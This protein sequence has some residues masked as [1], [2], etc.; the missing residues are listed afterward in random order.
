MFGLPS[1]RHLYLMKQRMVL[2]RGIGRPAMTAMTHG[3]FHRLKIKID[4]IVASTSPETHRLWRFRLMFPQI[5]SNSFLGV[6]SSKFLLSYCSSALKKEVPQLCP[7]LSHCGPYNMVASIPWMQFMFFLVKSSYLMVP[8]SYNA[9][10][11]TPLQVVRHTT[12]PTLDGAAF[13]N[14][15][16]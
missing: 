15:A 1:P 5:E 8:R 9:W 14:F 12:N 2:G 7:G 4:T 13:T 11:M 6:N 3:I 10:L 16:K